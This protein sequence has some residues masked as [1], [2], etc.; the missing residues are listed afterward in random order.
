MWGFFRELKTEI[1]M[2]KQQQC[3]FISLDGNIS[4]V[5][6]IMVFTYQKQAAM[7]STRCA[8]AYL[9]AAVANLLNVELCLLHKLYHHYQA[10]L[11]PL[12]IKYTGIPV[13]RITTHTY[14]VHTHN[15][16]RHTLATLTSV[17]YI[18][19][20]YKCIYGTTMTPYFKEN[21]RGIST[22]CIS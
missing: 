22:T 19:Y 20:T 18:L 14:N 3:K 13:L 7:Y 10:P 12:Q 21:R 11:S 4:N 17:T 6:V 8:Q 9:H 1:I 16:H 2:S 15:T 5:P